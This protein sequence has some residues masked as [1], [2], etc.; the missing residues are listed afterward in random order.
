MPG[1][2]TWR[3]GGWFSGGWVCAGCC[4]GRL[5][6]R[7]L[8]ALRQSGLGLLRALR[9]AGNLGRLPALRGAGILGPVARPSP[10]S[11]AASPGASRAAAVRRG[12]LL[13]LDRLLRLARLLRPLRPAELRAAAARAE[14]SAVR[15]AAAAAAVLLL[16]CCTGGWTCTPFGCTGG[17]AARWMRCA[18]GC[19]FAGGPL[20]FCCAIDRI[21]DGLREHD[22]TL[23]Q[24]WSRNRPPPCS[25]APR[26]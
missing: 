22:R 18:G 6:L 1:G 10:R 11:R 26:S 17:G 3:C 21:D 25:R 2:V 12:L 15:A 14:L 24:R 8:L 9:S 20:P 7:R 13:G 4:G 16:C 5:G 23:A 19:P